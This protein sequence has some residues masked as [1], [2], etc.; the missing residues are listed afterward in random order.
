M[1]DNPRAPKRHVNLSLNDDL[2][3]KVRA[4]TG[5]VSE[6]VENL[7]AE[8]L[9]TECAKRALAEG[10]LEQALHAWNQFGEDEPNFADVHSTL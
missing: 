8:Y 1:Q 3:Q 5:N 10:Q 7:L 2:V 9:E 4:L 6:R